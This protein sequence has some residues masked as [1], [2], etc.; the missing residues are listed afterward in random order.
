MAA[1][2]AQNLR[3]SLVQLGATGSSACPGHVAE[4]AQAR[5]ANECGLAGRSLLTLCCLLGSRKLLCCAAPTNKGL[6]I[7]LY[8]NFT[9]VHRWP[10]GQGWGSLCVR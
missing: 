10:Q 5:S 6:F 4:V 9:L 7:Y 8:D 1:H 2:P 3:V